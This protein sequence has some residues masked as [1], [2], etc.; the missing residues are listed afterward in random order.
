MA[1]RPNILFLLNDH[2]AYYRHGGDGGPAIQ[3]PNV[4]RLAAGQTS[5]SLVSSID[6]APTLLDAAAMHSPEPMHGASLLPL[7]SGACRTWR[8]DVMCEIHGHCIKHIGRAVVG[9]RYKYVANAPQLDELYD[10]EADPFE[11]RNLINDPA[12][13][14]ILDDMRRRLERW[15][16]QTDD[17]L[18]THVLPGS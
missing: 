2:Q 18:F 16:R 9:P 4:G 8:D 1:D 11:L 13:K 12:H 5:D 17:M 3:R 15:Q 7:A 14:T 6:V 10:I